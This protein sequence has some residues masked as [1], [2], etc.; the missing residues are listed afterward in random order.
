MI[1]RKVLIW[2]NAAEHTDKSH[3]IMM[4]PAMYEDKL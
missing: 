1:N 4:A 2:R 3:K